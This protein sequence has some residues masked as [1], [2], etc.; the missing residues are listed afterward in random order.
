MEIKGG[1]GTPAIE[2]YLLLE[3]VAVGRLKRFSIYFSHRIY[4]TTA[5]KHYAKESDCYQ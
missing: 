5:N 1:I 2:F 3:V 4:Y